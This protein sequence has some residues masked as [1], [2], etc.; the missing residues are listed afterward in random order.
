M[1]SHFENEYRILVLDDHPVVLE[2][3]QHLLMSQPGVTCTG[4]TKATQLYELLQSGEKFDLFILDLEL[5][6]ADGF[7]AL[8]NIRKCCPQAA[9][10]IYTMHEEPWI[11]AR[12]AHFDIQGVVS[13]SCP[14]SELLSAFVAVR[15]GK[16][17]YNEA[18]DE[19]LR[20]LQSCPPPSPVPGNA[21]QLTTREQDVLQ[22]IKEG[23]TTSQIS[24]RLYISR[25][26]VGTYRRRLMAKLDA[27]N[28]AQLIEKG[29]KYLH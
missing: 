24:E 3:V 6:D 22:C 2:G 26:T 29:R 28:V 21:F 27:H 18:F 7:D 5:P 12:L 19:Q 17:Y 23:L 13:K 25:N 14:V 9:I 8:G 20:R 1:N 15:A 11:V 16:T 4:V 10:L